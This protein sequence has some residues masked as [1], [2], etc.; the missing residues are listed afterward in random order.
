[1]RPSTNG[2]LLSKIS[3]ERPNMDSDPP[4][5]VLKNMEGVIGAIIHVLEDR[6]EV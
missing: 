6:N 1:M 3:V 5:D 4:L 2:R